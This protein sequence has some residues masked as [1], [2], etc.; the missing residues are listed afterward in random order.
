M[1]L[2]SASALLVNVAELSVAGK[3]QIPCFAILVRSMMNILQPN[4]SSDYSGV[5]SSGSYLGVGGGGGGHT[6]L[7]V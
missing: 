2:I 4:S 5:S 3:K 1:Y 7:P 6:A